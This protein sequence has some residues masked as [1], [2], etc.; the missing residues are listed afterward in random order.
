MTNEEENSM[1][2][3]QVMEHPLID[4]YK[5]QHVRVSI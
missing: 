2:K 4:V 1:S 5:R 3:V